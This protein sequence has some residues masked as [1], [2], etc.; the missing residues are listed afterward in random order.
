MFQ[1]ILCCMTMCIW[2]TI[3]WLWYSA[4]TMD[5]ATI[6]RLCEG[7]DYSTSEKGCFP[8]VGYG[9]MGFLFMFPAV[10]FLGLTTWNGTREIRKLN[11]K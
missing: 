8:E 11:G 9:L 5:A 7:F 6:A 3:Y 4:Y 2:L 1:R 10:A